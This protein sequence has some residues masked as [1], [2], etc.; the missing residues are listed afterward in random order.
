MNTPLVSVIMPAY[1][2]EKYIAEAIHSVTEQTYKAWEL[3]VVDDGS[4]D[5]TASLIKEYAGKDNRI[6]YI[7][8][9]NGRQGKARN[10][11]LKQAG[12]E[13]IAFLDADDLWMPEKLSLQVDIMLTQKVDLT[14]SDAYV[15]EDK[16]VFEKKMNTTASYYQGEEAI[17]K[18][19]FFNHIPILTV[20]VSKA[21][22]DKVKGFSEI[23]GISEDYH[24]WIRLLIDGNSFLGI[25]SP[26][27][28]Y[29][30]HHLSASSGE[31]KQ[32]FL[33]LNCLSDIAGVWPEYKTVIGQSSFCMINDYLAKINISK[34]DMARRLLEARND[35]SKEKISLSFWKRVYL[36]FGRNIFRMLFNVKMKLKHLV[37]AN[38]KSERFH[39]PIYCFS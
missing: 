10:N 38:K 17:H 20:L 32:L 5:N 16:P 28:H 22:I 9:D 4:T 12:G 30:V 27:A 14:F 33:K 7:H 8:Q 6:R 1:N 15:F 36:I 2:A 23:E 18:F 35:L 3:I 31:S 34:W 11:G 25:V 37:A 24:L 21:A 13:Y 26:L 39:L 19:L 29:R